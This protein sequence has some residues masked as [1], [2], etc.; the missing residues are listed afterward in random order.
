MRSVDDRRFEAW[1][2]LNLACVL[3]EQGALEE[4]RTLYR[5]TL[6]R[7]EEVGNRRS[8]GAVLAQLARIEHWNGA[9]DRAHEL[10]RRA[11]AVL[12]AAG[13]TTRHAIT[14]SSLGGVLAD[15]GLR[16]D[17]RLA[18]E[19]AESALHGDHAGQ[20][21]L[22]VSRGHLDLALGDV[23]AARRR[24]VEALGNIDRWNVRFSR[25]GLERALARAGA[26]HDVEPD[27]TRSLVIG[28]DARWFRA[29]GG[30]KVDLARRRQLRLILAALG[31]AR[32][33]RPGHALTVGALLAGGWPGEQVLPEAGASRVYVAISTLRRM[34][35]RD[36]LQRVDDGYRID[37]DAPF[38]EAG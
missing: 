24:V 37:P 33:D 28:P 32:R 36:L 8:Q 27:P 25:I 22:E 3:Q 38:V 30:A 11:L 7:C 1:T 18:F 6:S 31:N 13:W 9:L 17:A 20:A 5:E 2:M 26:S 10:Y 15:L 14:T 21:A 35:L 16:D 19:R 29:P 34:G 4:A 12:A 23:A